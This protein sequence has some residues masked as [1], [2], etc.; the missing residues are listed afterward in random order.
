MEFIL[1]HK[2]WRA[3]TRASSVQGLKKEFN[4]AAY[5]KQALVLLVSG[6]AKIEG[7]NDA[8]LEDVNGK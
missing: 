8:V 5:I 4:M 3:L 6:L 7:T 2:Y 1:Y